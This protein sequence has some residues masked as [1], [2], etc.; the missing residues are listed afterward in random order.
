MRKLKFIEKGA[1]LAQEVVDIFANRGYT[2][3]V[4]EAQMALDRDE[5]ILLNPD[6]YTNDEIFRY[7]MEYF[8]EE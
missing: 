1:Q 4:V 3:S 2:I 5:Y 7:L 6:Y 8:V